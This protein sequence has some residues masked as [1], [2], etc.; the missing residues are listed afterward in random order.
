[1]LDVHRKK[2]Y[3]EKKIF[4]LGLKDGN[5]DIDSIEKITYFREFVATF[6]SL[7]EITEDKYDIVTMLISK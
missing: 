4:A 5:T 2:I 1:M 7:F 3:L 6:R